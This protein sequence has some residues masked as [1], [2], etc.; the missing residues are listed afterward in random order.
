MEDCALPVQPTHRRLK[1]VAAGLLLSVAG[2]MVAIVIPAVSRDKSGYAMPGVATVV[3]LAAAFVHGILG[4]SVRESN[5]W[6]ES[7]SITDANRPA[8][9][10]SGRVAVIALILGLVLRR[11]EVCPPAGR[12]SGSR[13]IVFRPKIGRLREIKFAL[14]RTAALYRK[15]HFAT[16]HRKGWGF[17]AQAAF[18]G[19]QPGRQF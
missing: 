17:P 6:R 1:A 4:W 3:F 7:L 2:I 15:L 8:A 12:H 9:S 5:Q 14:R 19:G 11:R 18:A 10:S 13:Q 16:A